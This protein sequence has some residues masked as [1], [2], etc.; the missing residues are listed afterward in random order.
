[1]TRRR[2]PWLTLAVTVITAGFFAW[3]QADPHLLVLLRRDP[4]GLQ[5]SSCYRV[6]TALLIQSDWWGQAIFNLVSLA[7]FG[8]VVEWVRPRW[9][10]LALYLGAGVVGQVLGYAWEPPGGGNSV[11]V[12]GLVGAVITMMLLATPELP[13]PARIFAAYYPAVLLGQ[14]RGALTLAIVATAVVV[15]AVIMLSG[16]APDRQ[17]RLWRGLAALLALEAAALT[18]LQNHHG[19]A[20]LMGM[21]LGALLMQ[22]RA[23][24]TNL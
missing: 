10:W 14:D 16:R 21:A 20:L 18:A 7:F 8:V 19:P 23:P 17:I 24:A 9:A 1:M 6:L 15:T 13:M 22:A 4:A 2:F 5:W 12:C 11:A 3:Q